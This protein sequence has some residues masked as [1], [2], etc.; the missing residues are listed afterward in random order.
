MMEH[1]LRLGADINAGC[2]RDVRDN[3][4][5]LVMAAGTRAA[6][7]AISNGWVDA[8]RVLLRQGADP[9]AADSVGS[10]LL[11]VAISHVDDAQR[12]VM[13]RTLLE[14][15]A[16]VTLKDKLN[17]VPLHVAAA[18]GSTEVVDMFLSWAPQT[19]NH[20][21]RNLSTPLMAAAEVRQETHTSMYLLRT[22]RTSRRPS[23]IV[24]ETYAG[25]GAATSPLLA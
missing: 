15:N 7:C 25:D 4:G 21:D 9:N 22:L 1:L 23:P 13:A 20:A 11:I 8:L 2:I 14:A 16:D 10:T 18:Q 5:G 17:R 19:L 6:H 24:S 12:V 3:S